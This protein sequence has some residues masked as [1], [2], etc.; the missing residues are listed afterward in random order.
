MRTKNRRSTL[1]IASALFLPLMLAQA[2]SAASSNSTDDDGGGT[3]ASSAIGG[4]SPGQGGGF[5]I[6]T[7]TMGQ[8]GGCAE[9]S[10]EAQSGPL[11]ADII[12]VVD[13]SGSMTDEAAEVQKSMNDFSNIIVGSGI[14]ARII[15]ISA[16]SN[17]SQGICV[18][19]PL[20]SG[21]CPNDENLPVFRHVAMSVG[22][23]NGL[24]LILSTY[25]QWK[26]QLRANATKTLAI[27]TDDDSSLGANDFAQQ[28]VALDSSFKDFKFNAIAAP[29]EVNPITCTLAC[30]APNC[31]SCDPC[32]GLDTQLG[33]FC[34]P[35][36]ADEGKVY[37][38][39]V[40]S[41]MGVFGDL[42]K[43]EFVPVFK[44]M[45]T[46]V[47]QDASVPCVYDIPPAPA[48]ETIDFDKVNVEY[49]A[50]A[51]SAPELIYK[52]SSEQACGPQGG[53]YY[54]EPSAPTKI[55]LCEA[56]CTAAQGS[57]EGSLSVKF[58]CASV[59]L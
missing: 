18:P 41:T 1:G 27:I 46:A 47:V 23:T 20:G 13:N 55:I 43:Q 8:G 51:G 29:Y 17:D 39:L 31:Q 49:K 2:C 28:L 16:D 37:K 7:S 53:W 54:D 12:F 32:C 38:Q 3:G 10:A 57:A 15:L 44:D 6:S 26:D 33:F 35:L 58:G 21:Q 25:P 14:D 11:P 9:T 45:A 24:E 22:S 59:V 36:P 30:Q 5:T 52:V 50:N 40:S 4:S 34:T 42:C 48:G 56:S 19:A